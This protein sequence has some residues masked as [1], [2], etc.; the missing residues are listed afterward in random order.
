MKSQQEGKLYPPTLPQLLVSLLRPSFPLL[1]TSSLLIS[2]CLLLWL[3]CHPPHTHT[4]T[5]HYHHSY[6]PLKLQFSFFRSSLSDSHHLWKAH[7]K[8]TVELGRKN[9]VWARTKWLQRWK[10]TFGWVMAAGGSIPGS[11][12]LAYIITWVCHP[13]L[14][15]GIVVDLESFMFN[16]PFL[17]LLYCNLKKNIHSIHSLVS[18]SYFIE[19]AA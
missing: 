19:I 9:D 12:L 4:H 1:I 14:F 8:T 13:L 2:F 3:L 11:W 16:F 17:F 6:P 10:W 15:S 5:D 7:E 18:Q